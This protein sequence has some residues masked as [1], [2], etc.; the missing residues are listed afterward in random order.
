M[1]IRL[2]QFQCFISVLFHYARRA[3]HEEIRHKPHPVVSEYDINIILSSPSPSTSK[4]RASA[5][6][7]VSWTRRERW[8]CCVLWRQ[9]TTW[10]TVNDINA[11]V[12]RRP[13]TEVEL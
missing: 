1:L 2:K 10:W 7:Q 4:Y 5:V 12:R 6:C 11:V 9:L 3:L 13:N 8:R